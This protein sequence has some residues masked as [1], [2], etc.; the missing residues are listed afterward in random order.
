MNS[1]H[2]SINGWMKFLKS[3]IDCEALLHTYY[4]K[5]R[6]EVTSM[7][8]IGYQTQGDTNWILKR[9]FVV[10]NWWI[11][12]T[13]IAILSRTLL[14]RRTVTITE[15][16]IK[17]YL[18]RVVRGRKWGMVNKA[19]NAMDHFSYFFVFN[20]RLIQMTEMKLFDFTHSHPLTSLELNIVASK[21]LEPPLW[22]QLS[23]SIATA[24]ED[25][26]QLSLPLSKCQSLCFFAILCS[27]LKR[28]WTV[29]N[30]LAAVNRK[31]DNHKISQLSF[32]GDFLAVPHYIR[33][34]IAESWQLTLCCIQCFVCFCF[35]WCYCPTIDITSFAVFSWYWSAGREKLMNSKMDCVTV[36]PG[37]NCSDFIEMP[38]LTSVVIVLRHFAKCLATRQCS[39][40]FFWQKLTLFSVSSRRQNFLQGIIDKSWFLVTLSPSWCPIKTSP[41][42]LSGL[43]S[44]L[45]QEI[46]SIDT[47]CEMLLG[48]QGDRCWCFFP[49]ETPF[50]DC[51]YHLLVDPRYL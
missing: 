6:G 15:P 45:L 30:E 38:S 22:C 51:Y 27:C 36:S 9:V 24:L 48:K 28:R 21:V 17:A 25:P 1:F 34:T 33:F 49:T 47:F 7:G 50:T 3:A 32:R 19:M 12:L 14:V 40:M 26:C 35:V 44:G 8:W 20:V 23:L 2:Q 4:K 16:P 39:P 41:H 29:L 37:L 46:S 11:L 31:Y 13:G 43:V 5:G 10:W 18:V 42:K